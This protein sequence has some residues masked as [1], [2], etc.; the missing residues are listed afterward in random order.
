MVEMDLH[1]APPVV[2]VLGQ[3]VDQRLVKLL[4]RIEIRVAEREAVT[5]PV[6]VGHL[7]VLAAPPLQPALLLVQV[8][9]AAGHAGHDRRLEVIGERD[10]QMLRPRLPEP[11]PHELLASVR[12]K[13]A[14]ARQS[15]R[16]LVSEGAHA[17]TYFRSAERA[18]ALVCS[19]RAARSP[20]SWARPRI[21]V[22]VDG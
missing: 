6:G 15:L 9:M 19:Q 1:L 13:P 20:K 5:V 8:G 16:H 18:G 11:A 21:F 10:D 2:T 14:Q 12:G 4:R 3:A 7:R 22:S 17:D